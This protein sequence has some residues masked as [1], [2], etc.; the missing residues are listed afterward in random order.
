[1]PDDLDELWREFAAETQETL[2]ALL[3]LLS[4]Q[5]DDGWQDAEIAGLFRYFHS[6]K[7]SCLVAGFANLAALAHRAEDLLSLVRDGEVAL[8]P[9]RIAILLRTVDRLIDQ[10]DR[11]IAERRDAEPDP[12]L[13]AELERYCGVG[14]SLQPASPAFAP[15]EWS[16]APAPG[17]QALDLDPDML[18][19]YAELLDQRMA[20]LAGAFSVAPPER[21]LAA[22]T[23]AELAHGA[24]IM[25]LANLADALTG[26]ATHAPDP[27]ARSAL[28]PYFEEL[29]RQAVLLEEFTQ[30]PAGIAALGLALTGSLAVEAQAALDVI[31]DASDERADLA[32]SLRAARAMFATLGHD[33]AV[34]LLLLLEDHCSRGGAS[35]VRSAPARAVIAALGDCL[36]ARAD[37]ALPAAA[38]LAAAIQNTATQG[39]FA[40]SIPDGRSAAAFPLSRELLATLSA[41]QRTR[42]DRAARER[43]QHVYRLLLA[44][45]AE[46]ETVYAVLAWLDSAVEAVTSRAARQGDIAADEFVILSHRPLSWVEEELERLDP[47]RRCVIACEELVAERGAASPVSNAAATPVIRVGSEALDQLMGEIGEMRSLLASLGQTLR[48]GRLARVTVQARRLMENL[49]AGASTPLTELLDG[50]QEELRSLGDLEEALAR[51]HRR[52]WEGGLALRVVPVATLFAR[53]ARGA[54]DLAQKLGKDVE[55]A[56]EGRDVRIDKSMVDLLVDPLAHIIRNA[57]DH[58]IEET[59]T[60]LGCGKSQRARLRLAATERTNGILIAVEDDGRGLDRPLILAKAVERGLIAADAAATL[61][62]AAVRALIF[63]PGFS[64]ASTVTGVSGRGVGLDVVADALARA[65]GTCEVESEPGAW[66]RFTLYLPISAALLRALLVEA[67]GEVLA[68]P[69]RHIAAVL[70]IE[71]AAIADDVFVHDG[72]IRPLRHL[73]RLLGFSDSAIGQA[74]LVRVA[75]IALNGQEFGLIVDQFLRFDDLFLKELS[76]LLATLPGVGGAAVLG[77]GR[78]VLVLDPDRLAS[79]IE[80]A[81]AASPG[82]GPAAMTDQER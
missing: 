6:L 79:L 76:P 43:G 53:V 63:R 35:D 11:A 45:E 13:L 23:A 4:D 9:E 69:E 54:R 55:L 26:I 61:D 39:S 82:A 33:R 58:G 18:Q 37:I 64:T 50:A 20:L 28:S 16:T 1:M 8:D 70:E 57:L 47:E 15:G 38:A 44:L 17:G 65:G 48:D 14:A 2:D 51:A 72:Q 32:S 24:E 67:A 22:E 49:P 31:R 21:V 80:G 19:L 27:A 29:R 3:W 62:D 71:P 66:T 36:A 59:A 10:R 60:R 68:L 5:H 56:I 78:P 34:G 25:G 52:I 46:A 12:A 30:R 40:A 73:G 41:E 42:L 81:A 75:L 7:G 74:P 77:D